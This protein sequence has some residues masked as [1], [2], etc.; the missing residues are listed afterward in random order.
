MGLEQKYGLE[1]L[2]QY[3]KGLELKVRKYLGL[4]HTFGEFTGAELGENPILER[5][6]KNS[7]CGN[8]LHQ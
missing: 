2:Q 3:D 7:I 6:N 1:M 5:A 4:I 8:V